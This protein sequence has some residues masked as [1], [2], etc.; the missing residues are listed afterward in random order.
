MNSETIK[1]LSDFLTKINKSK[2]NNI[3]YRGHS[4]ISYKLEPNI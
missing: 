2:R 1:S 3:F 4:D